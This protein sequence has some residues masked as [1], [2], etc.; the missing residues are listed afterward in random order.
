MAVI[1]LRRGEDN[2]FTTTLN[3]AV[4]EN[5]PDRFWDSEQLNFLAKCV[6]NNLSDW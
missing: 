5:I 2:L 1:W 3:H 4:L 6:F